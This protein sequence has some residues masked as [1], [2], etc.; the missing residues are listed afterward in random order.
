MPFHCKIVDFFDF[1]LRVG[2]FTPIRRYGGTLF[3]LFFFFQVVPIRGG[4]APTTRPPVCPA[5]PSQRR[6]DATPTGD[7]R[8][9]ATPSRRN[10]EPSQRRAVA[11]PSRRADAGRAIRSERRDADTR[12]ASERRRGTSRRNDAKTPRNRPKNRRN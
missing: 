4:S 1:S 9:D 11:T 6:A 3:A 7:H 10:A 12:G 2:I 8:S 5:E